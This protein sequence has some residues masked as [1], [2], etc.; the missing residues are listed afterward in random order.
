MKVIFLDASIFV[1]ENFLEGKRINEFLRL[2]EHEQLIIVLPQITINEVKSQF[3]KKIRTAINYFNNQ[4]KDKTLDILRNYPEA[5]KIPKK[6]DKASVVIQKFNED[7]DRRLQDARVTI[8]PYPV[9]DT[10]DIFDK[11]FK[12]EKPFHNEGNKK[13][14]FPDAF[15]VASVITWCNESKKNCDVLTT[16][17]DLDLQNPLLK[18]HLDYGRFLNDFLGSLEKERSDLLMK[19]YEENKLSF[20][21]MLKKWLS[22]ELYDI[23]LYY[24]VSNSMDVHDVNVHEVHVKIK[25]FEI[26]SSDSETFEIEI[27]ANAR[28]KITINIDDVSVSYKDDDTKNIIFP[29]TTDMTFET[30][31]DTTL[32]VSFWIKNKDDY[33]KEPEIVEF[34]NGKRLKIQASYEAD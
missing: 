20:K 19:L 10:K 18:I 31:F 17:S 16:D 34:N 12:G 24:G 21:K 7:F 26:V 14:E 9:I 6:L 4:M 3:D 11:Y 25:D 5:N 22:T 15:A 27:Y 33:D 23:S 32:N 13:H 8:L 28:A 30:E 29:E 1:A 2:A